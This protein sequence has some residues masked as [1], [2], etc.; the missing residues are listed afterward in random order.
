MDACR[1]CKAPGILQQQGYLSVLGGF[2]APKQPLSL[3]SIPK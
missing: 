3:P 1:L 2:S